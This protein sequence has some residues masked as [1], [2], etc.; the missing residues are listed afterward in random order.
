LYLWA[1]LDDPANSPQPDNIPQHAFPILAKS[2]KW[3]YILVS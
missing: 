1:S 3:W 2:T